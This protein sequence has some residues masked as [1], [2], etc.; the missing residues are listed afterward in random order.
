MNE[1]ALVQ[2]VCPQ[3]GA[4]VS[5]RRVLQGIAGLSAVGVPLVAASALEPAKPKTVYISFLLHGNMCYDRYTK[6]EIREKFPRIYATG[7]RALKAHPEVTAHIDFPGLTLLSLKHF[8]PWFMEELKPLVDRRQIAMAGCQYAASHALASDEESDLVASRVTMELM[9]RELQPD[10][11]AFFPQE[12]VFHPQLPYV[13]NQIGVRRLIVMPDG[14][15]RPR[16]VRGIDGSEVLVYPL[17]HRAIRLGKL[18]E[19]FDSHADGSFVMA[20]GDFEQLGNIGAY[21]EEIARLAQKG[22]IIRWT[23]VD[24]YEQEVGIHAACA[25]PHPF[26]QAREDREPSPSFS[27]WV[28]HPMDMSWHGHAVKALDAL[29]SAGFARVA[30]ALHGLGPV[31]VPLKQAWTS[32]PDNP[33]DTRFEEVGEYPETEELCLVPGGEPTLHS[34]AW[35]HALI[36]LNSDSSGWFPWTPRTLHR[37]T[38]LDASRAYSAEWMQRFAQQVASRVRKPAQDCAGYVLALN[39]TEARTAELS[40]PVEGALAFV[41]ADG[42]PLPGSATLREGQWTA[43]ARVDLPAYGYRLLGLK[44]GAAAPQTEWKQGSEAVSESGRAEL[45][46]GRLLLTESGRPIELAVAPFT[47][48]DPSGAA[49]QEEVKPDWS[50]ATT[51]VRETPFGREL[52][53]FTELAWAVWIRLVIGL[54]PDRV[55]VTAHVQVDMPRRIG[56]LKYDPEGLLLEFRGW[57]GRVRYDIPYATIEH[58][59]PEPSF[60]A[61]QR[62]AAIDAD[63]AAFAVVALGGNQS[64]RVAPRQG[65]VAASLGA[66]IQGRADTRPECKILPSGYA[67]HLITSGGDPFFGAYEHRF[68]LVRCPPDAVAA[69]ADRLRIGVPLLRVRPGSD[70]AWPAQQSLIRLDAPGVRVTAFR[71]SQET[72][73]LV[74]NNLS[75]KACEGRCGGEAFALPGF[76][77]REIA[78]G[79]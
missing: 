70:G 29:R 18:E 10:C 21:V 75:E 25:A 6:Q 54:R 51:R 55:E 44:T 5:R 58:V 68:A 49:A 67:E 3:Q 69:A 15:D 1:G 13:M 72:S 66:S 12:I 45:T 24:R 73:R 61:A 31:D 30:A 65:V 9:R 8:A 76:G 56:K 28:S 60:V 79:R 17:D 20:G 46:S 53:V 4:R 19:Y 33:W 57:P 64:F 39:P 27:R 78:V 22:K 34:R 37:E 35:H 48:R 7:L 50:R 32:L 59:N 41:A 47:L 36:G 63:G 62:F 52:E 40:L 23:T 16:R 42:S 74:L 71:V 38:V 11:S 14:W 2:E 77:I 26:G 43:S